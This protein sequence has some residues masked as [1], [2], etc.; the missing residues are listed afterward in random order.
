[1]T[2]SAGV[3]FVVDDD[4]SCMSLSKIS[5]GPSGCLVSAHCRI[6]DEGDLQLQQAIWTERKG[7]N[8]SLPSKSPE[9]AQ[10]VLVCGSATL[11]RKR[12]IDLTSVYPGAHYFGCSTSSDICGTQMLDDSLV[13]PRSVSSTQS[14]GG[15]P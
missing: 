10:L 9:R 7:W 5:S 15:T 14:S 3:V 4:A 11:L 13:V 6:S 8:P 1:M 12:L 2:N